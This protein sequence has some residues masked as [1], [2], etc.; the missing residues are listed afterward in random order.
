VLQAGRAVAAM[1]DVV[2]CLSVMPVQ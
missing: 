2:V 1:D